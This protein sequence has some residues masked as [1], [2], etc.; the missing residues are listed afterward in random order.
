MVNHFIKAP[1]GNSNSELNEGYV[2]APNH[3]KEEYHFNIHPSIFVKKSVENGKFPSMCIGYNVLHR[4]IIRHKSANPDDK[5]ITVGGDSSISVASI[6]AMNESLGGNL[7]VVYLDTL[8][9][10]DTDVGNSSGFNE[11]TVSMLLGLTKTKLVDTDYYLKP[12]QIIYFGL[13]DK[14]DL[15]IDEIVHLGIVFMTLEKINQLGIEE[16]I[17]ILDEL[18]GNTNVHILL[19]MNVFKKSDAPST[20]K[21]FDDGLSGID[22]FKLLIKI[23]QKICS[24]DVVEFN[25]LIGS[26]IQIK[27]TRELI[28]QCFINAFD[29]KEKHINI[30]NEHTEFL[31]YREASQLDPVC[32]YGWYIL[33]GMSIEQKTEMMKIVPQD[34]II[35][36][37]LDDG[38]DYLIARTTMDEQNKKSCYNLT[39]VQDVVLFPS[40]KAEMGFEIINFS[41]NQQN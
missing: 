7:K 32:D 39:T 15:N 37:E 30:V 9:D 16:S 12:E 27:M 24:M 11:K 41:Y 36:V 23:K 35:S 38:K 34:K 25:T 14:L 17:N 21:K 28:R 10:V 40:E 31:V 6:L 5:I 18:V 20:V 26:E 3:I 19:D 2:M 1:C 33:R 22:V 13:N 8:P 29:V 4:H